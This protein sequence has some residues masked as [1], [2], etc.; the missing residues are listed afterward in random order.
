M[1]RVL[2][3][4]GRVETG[5][6]G[7]EVTILNLINSKKDLGIWVR[8]IKY[9][10][11]LADV[12]VNK[13][14]KSLLAKNLIKEVKNI[15]NKSGKYY[16]GV[17]FEPSKEISGGDFYT[18]GKLDKEFL[19]VL[20]KVCL[21]YIRLQKVATVEGVLNNLKKER[22]VTFDISSQQVA[23]VLNS[24]VLDNDIMEVKSTGIGDFHS[25]PLGKM[26]FR[27]ASVIAKTGRMGD[28]AKLPCGACP[29][30]SICAID[31]VISPSKCVYYNSWLKLQF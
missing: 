11:K 7:D 20:R 2:G 16:M 29:V 9:E 10:S 1:S 28:F 26:C 24:M 23:E 21:K 19:Q 4:R 14:V 15:Q 22:V 25:I 5:P 30:T 12:I 17:E 31:G 13:S 27:V 3:K 18:E 8:H 6:V